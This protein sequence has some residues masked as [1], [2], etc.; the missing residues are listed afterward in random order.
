[1]RLQ[2]AAIY[3]ASAMR[4]TQ[5]R[6]RQRV[7]AQSGRG[8]IRA[9]VSRARPQARRFPP[10]AQQRGAFSQVRAARTQAQP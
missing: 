1:M 7:L 2:R 8:T 4:V 10:F 6:Q 5:R 3:T 9:K